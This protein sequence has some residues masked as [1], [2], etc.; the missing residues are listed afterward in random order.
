MQETIFENLN[1]SILNKF[2]LVI[3]AAQR[4]KELNHG[5]LAFVENKK[6]KEAIIALKEIAAGK[7]NIEKLKKSITKKTF[8]ES[9]E[10]IITKNNKTIDYINSEVLNEIRFLKKEKNQLPNYLF[11]DEEDLQE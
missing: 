8:M 10:R 5:A 3:V 2:D 6:D 9:Q 7:L 11:K 4:G 1:E